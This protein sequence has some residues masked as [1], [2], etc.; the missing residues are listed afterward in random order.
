VPDFINALVANVPY[1]QCSNISW[2]AFPGEW[3]LLK[4]VEAVLAESSS[5]ILGLLS[6]F[7]YVSSTGTPMFCRE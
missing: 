3:R 6:A 2:K 1:Q 7:G 4:R 5:N